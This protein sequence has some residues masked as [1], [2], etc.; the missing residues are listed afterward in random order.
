MQVQLHKQLLPWQAALVKLF[1]HYFFWAATFLE[2]RSNKWFYVVIP[3]EMS[4]LIVAIMG[5]I[6]SV[7]E[8][9]FFKSYIANNA[10]VS[11]LHL[12]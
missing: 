11:L 2:K 4:F 8:G 1:F 6:T 5:F 12:C 3:L 9:S 7:W 10:G